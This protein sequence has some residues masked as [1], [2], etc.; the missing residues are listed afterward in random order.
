MPSEQD[1]ARFKH[2]ILQR[3]AK[4]D[5]VVRLLTEIDGLTVA[6]DE[7]LDGKPSKATHADL[8]GKLAP[9]H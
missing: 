5:Q 9:G 8:I 2:L 6:L 1:A 3:A 4:S 7:L